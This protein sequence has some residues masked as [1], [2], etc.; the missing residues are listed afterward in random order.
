MRY[1]GYVDCG[2]RDCFCEAKNGECCRSDA[3]GMDEE[4]RS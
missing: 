4:V 1:V 3:Y 2:C